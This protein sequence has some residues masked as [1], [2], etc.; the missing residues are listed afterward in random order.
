[1]FG[2]FKS[3]EPTE[4]YSVY[5]LPKWGFSMRQLRKEWR[6]IFGK[7]GDEII[8]EVDGIEDMQSY[9]YFPQ[10]NI[11]F[12]SIRDMELYLSE[13]EVGEDE[14]D[15]NHSILRIP[16]LV[17]S[18]QA[19]NKLSSSKVFDITRQENI[20]DVVTTEATESR[21]KEVW[22]N[23]NSEIKEFLKKEGLSD[24]RRCGETLSMRP[25]SRI[26][27]CWYCGYNYPQLKKFTESLIK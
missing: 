11:S 12:E 4:Y 25:P 23:K 27:D 1:M 19:L 8:T 6:K 7:E 9:F 18:K 3:E 24:C 26:G 5:V 15:D 20:T 13:F 17:I 14:Y 10:N 2:W 16:R 21:L 22:A